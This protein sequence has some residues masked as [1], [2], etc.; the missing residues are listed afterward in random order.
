ML[1]NLYSTEHMARSIRPNGTIRLPTIQVQSVHQNNFDG[2]C[3]PTAQ[4]RGNV[5]PKTVSLA[6]VIQRAHQVAMMWRKAG[7]SHP[8]IPYPANY[9]GWEFDPVRCLNPPASA[10]TTNLVK[11]GCKRGCKKT[12]SCRNNNL[13]CTQVCRCANFSRNNHANSDDLVMRDLD[14]DE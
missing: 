6:L 14:A 3:S 10:A 1:W 9:C 2:S 7:E 12:C 13:P 8:R 4:L 5:F 11:C